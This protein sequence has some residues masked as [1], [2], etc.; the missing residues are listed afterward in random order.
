MSPVETSTVMNFVSSGK[1]SGRALGKALRANASSL[2]EIFPEPSV[3]NCLKTALPQSSTMV[4]G[5]GPTPP[6]LPLTETMNHQHGPDW[7]QPMVQSHS[8]VT[9]VLAGQAYE[10]CPPCRPSAGVSPTAA[11]L[12]AESCG[13]VNAG[14]GA[15]ALFQSLTVSE[16]VT[17]GHLGRPSDSY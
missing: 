5:A 7:Q 8:G 12:I 3:S 17:D 6:L 16:T 13:S 9:A 10:S 14:G 1:V 2:E 15:N 4:T 11:Q